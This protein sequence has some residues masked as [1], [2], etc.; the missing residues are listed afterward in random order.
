MNRCITGIL[1]GLLLTVPAFA[2]DQAHPGDAGKDPGTLCRERA[3][4]M[5]IKPKFF[6]TY[7]QECTEGYVRDKTVQVTPPAGVSPEGGRLGATAPDASLNATTGEQAGPRAPD[8]TPG[9]D[10]QNRQYRLGG[11]TPGPETGGTSGYGNQ[12]V[13][14]GSSASETYPDAMSRESAIESQSGE[15]PG[16]RDRKL[17]GTPG[18]LGAPVMPGGQEGEPG[19]TGRGAEGGGSERSPGGGSQPA[20]KPQ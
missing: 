12:N 3:E 16:A 19:R 11:S 5:N 10:D 17:G 18:S 9:S 8:A 20:G 6:D 7:V 2:A 14:G 13:M 1:A 4:R 15:A